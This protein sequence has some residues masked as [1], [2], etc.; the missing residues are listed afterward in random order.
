MI[1]LFTILYKIDF[2][3][4]PS[5]IELFNAISSQFRRGSAKCPSCGARGFMKRHASYNRSLVDYHGGVQDYIVSVKR[6]ACTS[7]EHTHAELPDAIVPYKSYCII[8]I[9]MALKEYFHTRAATAVC[10]KYK[11][12]PSTLYAWRDRYLTHASLDLGAVVE[13]ALLARSR[14]LS[15]AHDICRSGAPHDYFSRFGLSF[16]QCFGQLMKTTASSS[17]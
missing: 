2:K 1:R 4:V 14:W 8:F 11:I 15:D 12:A 6:S 17:A 13:A 5:G 9:L 3:H 10:A 7:C 16:L